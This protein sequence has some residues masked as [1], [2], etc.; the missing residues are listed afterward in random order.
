R[1]MKSTQSRLLVLIGVILGF[2]VPIFGGRPVFVMI[3]SQSLAIIV[4]PLVLLLMLVIITRLAKTNNYPVTKWS[5][6]FFGLIIIFTL[7][8]AIAGISG[9][10]GSF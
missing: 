4:T 1:D 8:M 2:A 6:I 5:N 7:I 10:I 9:I 3:I